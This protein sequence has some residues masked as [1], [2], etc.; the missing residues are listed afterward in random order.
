MSD[1]YAILLLTFLGI[2]GVTGIVAALFERRRRD[3]EA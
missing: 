2:L 1:T 3:R